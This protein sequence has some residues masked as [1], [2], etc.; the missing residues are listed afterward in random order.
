MTR[1]KDLHQQWLENPE[2]QAAHSDMAEEVELASA[3]IHARNNAGITQKEL[4]GRMNAKQSFIARLE[5]G[6][7]NT[8][9]KTLHRIAD[10]TGTHLKISF[11]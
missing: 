3:V 5:S 11:E 9:I 8:T 1:V 6:A 4:A 10:A 7:Q 2:Y